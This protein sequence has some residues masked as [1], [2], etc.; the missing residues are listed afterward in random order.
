MEKLTLKHFVQ[1]WTNRNGIHPMYAIFFEASDNT[2]LLM[3]GGVDEMHMLD[4]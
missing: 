4:L 1:R 2:D 3:Q